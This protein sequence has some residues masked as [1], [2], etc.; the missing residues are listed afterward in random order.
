MAGAIDDDGETFADARDHF[1]PPPATDNM[2]P[3]SSMGGAAATEEGAFGTQLVSGV[4]RPRPIMLNY[5]R[6]AK[7]VDV[8]LLKDN[9]WTGMGLEKVCLTIPLN[10]QY[11]Y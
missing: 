10:V 6:K 8:R 9:I 5:A 2:V 7:N 1:S 3:M 11:I 4:G